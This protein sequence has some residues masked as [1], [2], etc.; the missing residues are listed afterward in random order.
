MM[1]GNRRCAWPETSSAGNLITMAMNFWHFNDQQFTAFMRLSDN[2]EALVHENVLKANSPT[3]NATRL[4]SW[5]SVIL[6]KMPFKEHNENF[7]ENGNFSSLTSSTWRH[8][9]HG[10]KEIASVGLVK[11]DNVEINY[12]S[13]IISRW[14]WSERLSAV[15][16]TTLSA[17]CL[18][19]GTRPSEC[20][21]WKIKLEP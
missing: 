4:C 14:G 7:I 10:L 20:I 18:L 19:E 9:I 5:K 8:K 15:N 6:W 21:A 11:V 3:V 16:I 13:W 2:V 17:V 1:A 12:C